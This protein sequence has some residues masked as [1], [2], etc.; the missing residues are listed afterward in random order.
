MAIEDDMIEYGYSD[1]QE[2]FESLID[3]FDY[4]SRQQE[5]EEKREREREREL[6]DDFNLFYDED[7]EREY[8]RKLQKEEEQRE[9]ETWVDNWKEKNPDLAIIWQAYFQ[10]LKYWANMGCDYSTRLN[11]C[12][13]LKKWLDKRK[14]FEIERKKTVWS[15]IRKELFSL[16]KNELFNFYFPEDED[17]I[18]MTI[19]Q[20]QADELLS[21]IKNEP[22]LWDTICS[23]YTI[24]DTFFEGIEDD[25][26]WHE[27]YNCEMDFEYWKDRNTEQYNQFAKHRIANGDFFAY[28]EWMNHHKAEELEWK[29]ENIDL[30]NKFKQNY[31]IRERNRLIES[32][33]TKPKGYRRKRNSILYDKNNTNYYNYDY[34]GYTIKNLFLPDLE[35][36][37]E[38]PF[39]ENV[40]DKDQLD[41]IVSFDL[42]S[43]YEESSIYAD[44]VLTQLWLYNNRDE[45][46]MDVVKKHQEY[47][48]VHS[49]KFSKELLL[50][51]KK[52]YITEWNEFLHSKVPGYQKQLEIV[53]EFRLWALDGNKEAFLTLAEKYLPNWG[54]TI[55]YMYGQD[56]HNQ[57]CSYFYNEILYK[58]DFLGEDVDYIKKHTSES[59]EIK[60]WQKELQDRLLWNIFY[61]GKY[62]KYYHIEMMYISM[63]KNES[64]GTGD[65]Y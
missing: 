36:K 57:M 7:T 14:R 61:E 15:D 8:Y 26:F 41:S 5:R 10:S 35:T 38:I 9:N 40:L 59:N 20:Q 64:V 11:E 25:A 29:N 49:M 51:W 34:F 65:L 42:S 17:S 31:V 13:E 44:K 18:N 62:E 56:I 27:L 48:L 33:V 3:E 16:Y 47:N 55:K 4:Y 58:T 53:M 19:I 21:L 32:L 60:I 43:I 63:N 46:E 1:A 37:E 50:W 12:F 39:D 30:G 28:G 52:K 22:S 54:K 23:S 6:D 45:W 2:Y 24:D